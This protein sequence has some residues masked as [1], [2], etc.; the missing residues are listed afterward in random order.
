MLVG[1]KSFLE[2]NSS[3]SKDGAMI[4]RDHLI[5]YC[6]KLLRVQQFPNFLVVFVHFD[7][8]L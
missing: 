3:L 2:D 8:K 5:L 7:Q 4:D 1:L 6:L